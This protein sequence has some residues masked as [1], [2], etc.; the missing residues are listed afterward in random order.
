METMNI[1]HWPEGFGGSKKDFLKWRVGSGNTVEIFDIEVAS[2]HRR[3]GGGRWM[4]N[5]LVDHC[6]PEGTKLVWAITRA[7]NLKAHEFYEEMKFRVVAVL[8]DFYGDKGSLGQD[9]ADAIMFGRY[10]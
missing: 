2:I 4:V 10:I 5:F 6:L 8:R 7:S 1:L 3:Q 9:Q